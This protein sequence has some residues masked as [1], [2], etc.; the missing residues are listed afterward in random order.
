MF[1]GHEAFE[2]RGSVGMDSA[3]ARLILIPGNQFSFVIIQGDEG[4]PWES[5]TD[6]FSFKY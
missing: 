5:I 1:A 2:V 4:E 6:S 3:G